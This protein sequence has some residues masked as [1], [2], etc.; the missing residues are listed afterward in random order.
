MIRIQSQARRRSTAR[1]TEEL[2][3]ELKRAVEEEVAEVAEKKKKKKKE[4]DDALIDDLFDD[5]EEQQDYA[6]AEEQFEQEKVAD[7][8][9]AADDTNAADD[10]DDAF[11]DDLFEDD[12]DDSYGSY[13]SDKNLIAAPKE[14]KDVRLTLKKKVV[15]FVETIGGLEGLKELLSSELSPVTSG[16]LFMLI[17][18]SQQTLELEEMK[19][20]EVV[21]CAPDHA[22]DQEASERLAFNQNKE[23]DDD[24][25]TLVNCDLLLRFVGDGMEKEKDE[26]EYNEKNFDDLFEDDSNDN[27]NIYDDDDEFET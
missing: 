24:A 12:S 20:F 15:D 3:N 2:K 4:E 10:D 16:R 14:K 21:C 6:T 25:P 18:E 7:D 9:N 1:R 27:E 13:G 23:D 8:K 11:F 5:L 22:P 17:A 19:M 26:E